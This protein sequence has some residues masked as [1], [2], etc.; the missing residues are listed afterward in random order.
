MFLGANTLPTLACQH[1]YQPQ[2]VSTVGIHVNSAPT[3]FF[4]KLQ[5][6]V[7]GVENT[8]QVVWESV[9]RCLFATPQ[10]PTQLQKEEK[11]GAKC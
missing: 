6:A 5:E 10:A 7:T 8:V 4:S 11:E 1:Q 2:N 9:G 3:L